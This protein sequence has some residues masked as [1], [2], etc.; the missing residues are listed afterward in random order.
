M[1]ECVYWVVGGLD[2][3]GM[4]CS[5]VAGSGCAFDEA[6]SQETFNASHCF[7]TVLRRREGAMGSAPARELQ[8][9]LH[10]RE[11]QCC[12]PGSASTQY[13]C[14]R[15][16]DSATPASGFPMGVAAAS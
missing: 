12:F 13:L 8:L 4:S 15:S 5:N 16:A 11:I 1:A 7:C 9:G 6:P 3:L 10:S 2:P 14:L